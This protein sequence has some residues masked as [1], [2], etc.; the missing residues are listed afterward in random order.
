MNTSLTQPAPTKE[1]ISL[2][3]SQLWEKAGHPSGLDLEFWLEA[4]AQLLAQKKTP[5]QKVESKAK[6]PIPGIQV[7]TVLG[8]KNKK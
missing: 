5:F 2:L 4:E 1:Q 7:T 8:R 3:A 6:P